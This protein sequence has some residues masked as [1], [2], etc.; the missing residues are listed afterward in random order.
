MTTRFN[1]NEGA[2]SWPDPFAY[3]EMKLASLVFAVTDTTLSP[4]AATVTS[5]S[6]RGARRFADGARQHKR[7]ASAPLVTLIV[8]CSA[9]ITEKLLTRR[10][11]AEPATGHERT[12]AVAPA[13]TR[14][15]LPPSSAKRNP[16]TTCETVS[17]AANWVNTVADLP[18]MTST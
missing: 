5:S 3:T 15:V 6:K 12:C 8:D 17:P 18:A 13:T 2:P 14:T 7:Q 4:S 16:L 9:K 10:D 1:R 11:V